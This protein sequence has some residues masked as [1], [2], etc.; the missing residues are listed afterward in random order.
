MHWLK[1]IVITGIPLLLTLF[2]FATVA[3][4][5]REYS[6]MVLRCSVETTAQVIGTEKELITGRSNQ[7]WLHPVIRFTLQDKEFC[8]RC[9]E[10]MKRLPF[11]LGTRIPIWYNPDDPM[12]VHL[13][14]KYSRKTTNYTIPMAISIVF[15]VITVGCGIFCFAH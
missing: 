9:E 10:R 1:P 7:S 2:S 14:G 11:K 4:W 5:G 6:A 12:D 13:E 8:V 3:K 15:G